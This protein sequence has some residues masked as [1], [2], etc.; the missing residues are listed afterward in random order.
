MQAHDG[1][2]NLMK[3][4]SIRVALVVALP[5]S[6]ICGGITIGFHS[7]TKAAA[8]SK[9]E[10]NKIVTDMSEQVTHNITTKVIEKTGNNTVI[11]DE[12]KVKE[13]VGETAKQQ[14]ANVN[15]NRLNDSTVEYV[16]KHIRAELTPKLK[17]YVTKSVKP[18][19]SD[20][21]LLTESDINSL[22]DSVSKNASDTVQT[23]LSGVQTNVS[24]LKKAISSVTSN[25]KNLT[26]KQVNDVTSLNNDI[27]SIKL[28]K[29][30]EKT[31][32]KLE[33][34]TKE[35][36][37][38]KTD[39]QNS[40]QQLKKSID[41]GDSKALNTAS[42]NLQAA[43]TQMQ[44]LLAENKVAVENTIKENSAMSSSDVNKKYAELQNLV[45]TT[46]DSL[47][48]YTELAIKN[49]KDVTTT[50]NNSI[51]ESIE[52]TDRRLSE[53]IASNDENVSNRVTE[54][55][56]KVSVVQSGLDS[57]ILLLKSNYSSLSATQKEQY[58]ELIGTTNDLQK[59]IE[60]VQKYAMVL[61]DS[62]DIKPFER[63]LISVVKGDGINGWVA[64]KTTVNK[65]DMSIAEFVD[66]LAKNDSTYKDSI[67][68]LFE[69]VNKVSNSAASSDSELSKE[70]VALQSLTSKQSET[71]TMLQDRASLIE[72]N[73]AQEIQN[74]ISSD[75]GLKEIISSRHTEVQESLK[76]LEAA[77]QSGDK[78]TADKAANDL[79]N[80]V[81]NLS[82][83]IQEHYTE[84]S[85]TQKSQADDMLAEI[86]NVRS[87]LQKS[88]DLTNEEFSNIKDSISNLDK[89]ATSV[90]DGLQG[91]I[92]ALNESLSSTNSE[93][94]SIGSRVDSL[95][96]NSNSMDQSITGIKDS[97]AGCEFF[98]N[99]GH[100]YAKTNDGGTTVIKKLD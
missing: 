8:L 64:T 35:L 88:D 54:L 47:K 57:N 59:G 67:N 29:K 66:T 43:V 28:S 10:V 70:I 41:A 3:S 52:A 98:Y 22:V 62:V 25:V 30:Q 84:L 1:V 16:Q 23:H 13:I 94:A 15:V 90:T 19:V 61:Q 49:S 14:L 33:S 11:V 37:V 74:R 96:I 60:S 9:E 75:E 21:T 50:E 31:V 18:L 44:N 46:S 5:V 100:F 92:D 26:S 6:I 93:V 48:A 78:S 95:E 34:L 51:K 56:N 53:Y 4:K 83:V 86:A 40:I 91:S 82:D 39:V 45:A 27:K 71:I 72:E 79:S 7:G 68:D 17:T 58:T 69:Y 36:T 20:K 87:E 97:L 65:Q 63:N 73:A 81:T 2:F 12:Q 77:M 89:S 80:A 85:A 42:S 24:D 99:D 55:L 32:T 38:E 76:V